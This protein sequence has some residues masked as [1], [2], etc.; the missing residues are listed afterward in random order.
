MSNDHQKALHINLS[1]MFINLSHVSKR[2]AVNIFKTNSH[3]KQ[4]KENVIY[5]NISLLNFSWWF[6]E[7]FFLINDYKVHRFIDFHFFIWKCRYFLYFVKLPPSQVFKLDVV[8]ANIFL[9]FFKDM[10]Q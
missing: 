1:M 3:V 5:P 7:W 8:Q 2:E 6:Q 9:M 4:N 10:I